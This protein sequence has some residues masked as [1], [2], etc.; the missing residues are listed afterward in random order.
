M[1]LDIGTIETINGLTDG[2]VHGRG[3]TTATE[4]WNI[5][6]AMREDGM[7]RDG[8]ASIGIARNDRA[9]R[10]QNSKFR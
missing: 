7:T 8:T 10:S 1:K 2:V 6:H 9:V 4:I 3:V 5:G